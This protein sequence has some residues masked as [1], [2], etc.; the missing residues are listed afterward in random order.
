MFAADV[1]AVLLEQCPLCAAAF[2]EAVKVSVHS[3][4]IPE[5]AIDVKWLVD[6]TASRSG[7]YEH[8]CVQSCM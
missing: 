6:D 4:E 3:M 7:S 2:E 8:A 1:A 5:L